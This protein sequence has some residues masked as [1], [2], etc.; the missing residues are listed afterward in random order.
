MQL[1]HHLIE[2]AL[3]RNANLKNCLAGSITESEAEIARRELSDLHQ[4][5]QGLRRRYYKVAY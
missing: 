4:L 3:R 1:T 2:A 5:N